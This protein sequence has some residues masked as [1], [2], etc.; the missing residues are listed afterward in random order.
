MPGSVKDRYHVVLNGYNTK[1]RFFFC[2]SIV[3]DSRPVSSP[4]YELMDSNMEL[5]NKG[6]ERVRAIN[7][8]YFHM[9]PSKDGKGTIVRMVNYADFM[10]GSTI[11]NWL[12]CKGFYPGVYDRM[13]AKF[14]KIDTTS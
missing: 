5:V 6:D 14:E 11:M 1:D 7:T 9:S 3:H 4:Y 10:L 8:F 12:I 13:K 2:K